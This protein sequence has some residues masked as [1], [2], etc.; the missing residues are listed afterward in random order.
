MRG[1]PAPAPRRLHPRGLIPARAGKTTCSTR[2]SPP[3]TAHPRACGENP[4]SVSPRV[5][6]NGSSPRVRGKLVR[7]VNAVHTS[8]LIPAR[9]GKTSR[10]SPRRPGGRAHP[11]ACGEN[12]P[13]PMVPVWMAGS[14][15][16]VRGKLRLPGIR[17]H[18][19]RLIPARAGKTTPY[20]L[21]V[22]MIT[23]HPRACGENRSPPG[24]GASCAGSSPRVRGKPKLRNMST[25]TLGLI[26]ARAGKTCANS[27]TNTPTWAHPRACGENVWNVL[28][29]IRNAGSSPRVRGK[30]R[31]PRRV[32]DPG[33][34]IP[35]RAGKT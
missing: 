19:V 29:P 21:R 7:A 18:G 15:P 20:G 3:T 31:R 33:G 2:G 34:L 10:S 22:T 25:Q 26:P 27:A 28:E 12:L 17:A 30:P 6:S 16:R 32:G 35:A 23:A 24:G 8:G 9:A 13:R 1:K 5:L 14:S 11:R 4:T